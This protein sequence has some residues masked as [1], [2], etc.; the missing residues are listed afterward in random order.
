MIREAGERECGT[1][2]AGQQE[3][4]QEGR[5]HG[6]GSEASTHLRKAFG[7]DAGRERVDHS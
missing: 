6:A 3:E 5:Y 1:E 2:W 4:E 7:W